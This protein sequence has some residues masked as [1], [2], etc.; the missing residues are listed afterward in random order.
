MKKTFTM[1]L[2]VLLGMISCSRQV[3]GDL[4]YFELKGSVSS[5]GEIPVFPDNKVTFDE[6]GL[7]R[8][9]GEVTTEEEVSGILADYT[10]PFKVVNWNPEVADDGIYDYYEPMGVTLAYDASGKLVM[11]AAGLSTAYLFYDKNGRLCSILREDE[12]MT[13]VSEITYDRDGNRIREYIFEPEAIGHEEDDGFYIDTYDRSRP[14][15]REENGWYIDYDQYQFDKQG[16]WI[17]RRVRYRD[18]YK[19]VTYESRESR[20][21][22]ITYAL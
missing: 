19:E 17:S 2:A 5:L 3:T 12:G 20:E 14:A 21:G 18:F 6:L 22:E 7:I 4:Q 15:D 9:P 11:V 8:L 10:G 13:E 1:G 16:N